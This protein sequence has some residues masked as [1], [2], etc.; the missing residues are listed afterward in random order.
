M[1][2]SSPLSLIITN[3]I[4]ED[5]KE[6]VVHKLLCQFPYMDGTFA[7]GQTDLTD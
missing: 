1:A 6:M 4:M 7:S 2:M 3:F 5:L